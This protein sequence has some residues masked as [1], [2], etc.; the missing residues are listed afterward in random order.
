MTAAYGGSPVFDDPLRPSPFL[1]SPI[2]PI[3]SPTVNPPSFGQIDPF[4]G[5]FFESAEIAVLRLR[6][7]VAEHK[8]AELRD[9]R[10]RA[11]RAPLKPE[12]YRVAD[13]CTCNSGRGVNHGLVAVQTCTCV[14]CDPEQTGST[15]YPPLPEWAENDRLRTENA[16]LEAVIASTERPTQGLYPPLYSSRQRFEAIER[17]VDA[18]DRRIEKEMEQEVMSADDDKNRICALE[19][20]IVPLRL[21]AKTAADILKR[22]KAGDGER[23]AVGAMT[24]LLTTYSA[25]FGVIPS[26]DEKTKS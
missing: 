8:L 12:D 7:D 11:C 16:R 21:F 13:G 2:E 20:E 1:P 10:C 25:L 15:R 18:I 14:T 5:G 23:G 4:T 17:R 22:W 9:R 3:N 6:A 24:V 19:V 26:L